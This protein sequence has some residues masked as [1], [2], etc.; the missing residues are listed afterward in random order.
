MSDVSKQ[1]V[2]NIRYSMVGM[3]K[4]LKVLHVFIEGMMIQ[5]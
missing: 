2:R 1:T 4:V 5:D 3:L